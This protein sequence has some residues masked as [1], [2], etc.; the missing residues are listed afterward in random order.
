MKRLLTPGGWLVYAAV[1]AALF[2]ILRMTSAGERSLVIADSYIYVI[3][4]AAFVAGVLAAIAAIVA[5]G[6]VQY[7]T[8]MVGLALLAIAAPY[9]AHGLATPGFLVDA[10]QTAPAALAAR[11]GLLIPAALLA[12][13]AFPPPPA[14]TERIVEN[15]AVVLA[16][17]RRRAGRVRGRHG[18]LPIGR[19]RRRVGRYLPC[20]HARRDRIVRRRRRMPPRIPR[21]AR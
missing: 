10:G 20:R 1:H 21:R 12:G 5:T 4:A 2:V 15:R 19:P 11:L 8:L 3:T 13:A 16:I 7:R 14:L 18:R 6:L 9:T 17:L